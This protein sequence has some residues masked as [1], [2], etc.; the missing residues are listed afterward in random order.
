[1]IGE[2]LERRLIIRLDHRV[3]ERAG[4]IAFFGTLG[5]DDQ[6][7]A[8]RERHDGIEIDSAHVLLFL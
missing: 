4:E 3:I 1:M 5:A 7:T 6:M 8:I 2:H